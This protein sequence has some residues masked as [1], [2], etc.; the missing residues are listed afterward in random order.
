VA[1]SGTN[2][3]LSGLNVLKA[4]FRLHLVA[5]RQMVFEWNTARLYGVN[6]SEVVE[7]GVAL[8]D[9]VRVQ[10]PRHADQRT[11][12]QNDNPDPHKFDFSVHQLGERSVPGL[13][14]LAVIARR[15][16]PLFLFVE[17]LKCAVSTLSEHSAPIYR[18]V[19]VRLYYCDVFSFLEPEFL[20]SQGAH[21][22]R[23]F[24]FCRQVLVATPASEQFNGLLVL[25]ALKKSWGHVGMALS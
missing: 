19:L 4:L 9:L 6:L 11:D 12:G 23:A 24:L 18:R 15:S 14:A 21:I 20:G 25:K 22:N 5:E 7:T 13:G 2:R 17:P 3:T 8:A 16:F 10:E 1:A